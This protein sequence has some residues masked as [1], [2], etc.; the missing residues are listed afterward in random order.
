LADSVI[1]FQEYNAD[2]MEFQDVNVSPIYSSPRNS[3]STLMS[4]EIELSPYAKKYERQVHN[5]EL[6]FS[7]AGGILSFLIMFLS[8]LL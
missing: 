6:F 3:K 1:G 2:E 5:F 7:W 4:Y 8:V